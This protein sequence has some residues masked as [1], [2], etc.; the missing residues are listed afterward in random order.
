MIVLGIGLLALALAVAM[1]GRDVG[2]LWK[3]VQ[4]TNAELLQVWK[5]MPRR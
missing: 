5:Q 1:L 4:E 2:R 3:A